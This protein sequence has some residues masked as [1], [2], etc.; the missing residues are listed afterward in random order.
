[1]CAFSSLFLQFKQ[2]A[3]IIV[4]MDFVTKV[5][6]TGDIGNFLFVFLLF[7][8][9]GSLALDH[10]IHGR[11]INFIWLSDVS[12]LIGLSNIS[13]LIRLSDVSHFIGFSDVS[14]G[15]L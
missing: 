2:V 3:F 9:L 13:H 10:I 8:S 12:H 1:M 14:F 15:Y 4:T 6:V 5:F 7:V 11:L